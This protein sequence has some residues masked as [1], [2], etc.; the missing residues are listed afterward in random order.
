MIKIDAINNPRY[1]VSHSV[2]QSLAPSTW[3]DDRIIWGYMVYFINSYRL[4][5]FNDML[6]IAF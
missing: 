2:M 5:R 1:E 3:I 6:L 4:I